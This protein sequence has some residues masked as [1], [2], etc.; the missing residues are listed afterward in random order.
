MGLVQY[1]S[2]DEDENVQPQTESQVRAPLSLTDQ[3]NEEYTWMLTT[4]VLLAAPSA[5]Q[6]SHSKHRPECAR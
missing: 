5:S 1:D 3:G 2:S 4:H 6:A